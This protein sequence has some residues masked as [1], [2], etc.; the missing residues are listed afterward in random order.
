MTCSEVINASIIGLD[1]EYIPNI[2]MEKRMQIVE[3][4]LFVAAFGSQKDSREISFCVNSVESI[5]YTT[6]S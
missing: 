6:S 2:N 5:T 4:N 3:S 1:G